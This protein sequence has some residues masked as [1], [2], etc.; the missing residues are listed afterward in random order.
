MVNQAAIEG[1][2]VL[3]S[4]ARDEASIAPPGARHT[5][6]SGRLIELLAHGDP[7][8]GREITLGSAYTYLDR[9]LPEAGYPRPRRRTVGGADAFV[10]TDNPAYGGVAEPGEP[11][12]RLRR[13]V[14]VPFVVA[15]ALIA[16]GAVPFLASARHG[17]SW[18]TPP[19]GVRGEIL[20]D[21]WG[22]LLLATTAVL[23]TLLAAGP[24]AHWVT[25]IAMRSRWRPLRRLRVPLLAFIAFL[26]AA[27]LGGVALDTGA[28]ARVQLA[29]CP[30]TAHVGVLVPAGS[31]EPAAEVAR[32][33]ERDTAADN[34]GCPDARLL[35][36]S[37]PAADIATAL[38]Q[39]WGDDEHVRIGPRPDV[40]LP[41]WSGETRQARAAAAAAGRN[42]PIA[43]ERTVATT[44]VVLAVTT[45]SAAA[46]TGAGLTDGAVW[47]QQLESMRRAG[48]DSVAAD[49]DTSLGG[50][51]RVALY[52]PP[53][54]AATTPAQV[55]TVE[56]HIERSLDNGRHALGADA[57]T[58]LCAPDG[59]R[60]RTGYL[61]TEQ[62]VA[63]FNSGDPLG[64]P[65]PRRAGDRLRA[66]YAGQTPVLDRQAVRFT[67]PGGNDRRTRA[68][69]RFTAWLAGPDGATALAAAG[70]RA[71]EATAAGLLSPDRGVQPDLQPSA[72]T[73]SVDLVEDARTRYRQTHR[74]GR[75]LI[76]IDASGSM[77]R[78]APGGSLW[79]LA[80]GGAQHAARL[81]GPHDELGV[82]AFQGAGA[83]GVRRLVPVGRP[84]PALV[85][86]NLSRVRPQGPAPLYR[87]IVA[88]LAEV[89]PTTEQRVTAVVLFTDGENDNASAL[90]T[91]QF[92]AAVTDKGVRVFAIAM[93]AAGCAAPVLRTITTATAGTCLEAGDGT[94]SEQLATIFEAVL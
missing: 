85:G 66:V 45:R 34:F 84:Q 49:P 59:L 36:Y 55:Q 86:K 92:R 5:A 25:E 83:S 65:C 11:L 73:V 23:A 19:P 53:A 57:A 78:P 81:L 31:H 69:E 20:Q 7:Q 35:V 15:A 18:R 38:G 52:R 62:A 39:G 75:V 17:G 40:W 89:G 29:T 4:A 9:V 2:Y 51:A 44:P 88:G 10:L 3:T 91:R 12:P 80:A 48:W 93:G 56:R 60:D 63:R 24:M 26:L 61:V 76:A 28:F 82:W 21:R 42:L 74:P 79:R 71:P 8:G 37:A 14:R 22:L 30:T 46:A 6:F 32:A 68:T 43:E 90:D 41:D 58:L 27:L 54:A 47:P 72:T 13:R 64:V 94:V 70:L 67:W 87:T 77:G 33:F 50:L 16:T 1:A